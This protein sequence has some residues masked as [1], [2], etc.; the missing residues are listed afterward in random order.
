MSDVPAPQTVNLNI[1]QGQEF[2]QSFVLG[3]D[4]DPIVPDDLTGMVVTVELRNDVTDAEPVATWGSVDGHI[5]IDGPN[6]GIAFNVSA[7]ETQALPT[8]NELA[9]YV[10]DMKMTNPA[11]PSYGRRVMQ[12]VVIVNPAVTR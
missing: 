4:S 11:D 2:T 12:G 6:G 9:V 1:W 5:T 8:D 7:D 10:Y 3:D